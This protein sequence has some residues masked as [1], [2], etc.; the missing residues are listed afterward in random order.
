M[1]L[2]ALCIETWRS[3]VAWSMGVILLRLFGFA[4]VMGVALRTM[5]RESIGLWYGMLS[6]TALAASVELGFSGTI[7]RM[8]S[9]YYAGATSVPSLGLTGIQGP[10]ARPNAG[11]LDGVIA[12]ARRV[13]RVLAVL[14]LALSA[15]AAVGWVWL[16]PSSQRL[17]T[18]ALAALALLV[19]GGT[20]NLSALFWPS[21][22]QGIHEV[23]ACNIYVALGFLA[24][25]ATALAGLGLGAGLVALAAGQ[26]VQSLA[27]RWLARRHVLRW[28]ES[29]E[30]TPSVRTRWQT[31]WPMTWRTGLAQ[32][33]AQLMLPATP[34]LLTTFS[35]AEAGS[36]GVSL[37]AA[38]LLHTLTASWIAVK[39]PV[40]SSLRASRQLAIVR[41]MA[42]Q[43]LALT[44][45]SFVACALVVPLLA[46]TVLSHIGSRTPFVTTEI[47]AMLA[48]ATGI[49]LFIGAHAALIQT[50]N[51]VSYLPAFVITGLVNLCA[52]AFLARSYGTTGVL[53]SA[54]VSPLL[55]NAWWLPR[56]AWRQL[57]MREH[58][59][60]PRFDRVRTGLGYGFPRFGPLAFKWFFKRAP[61]QCRV[62]LFP[63]IFI[64][65]DFSDRTFQSTY[66]QGRRF[67][68]PSCQML[69]AWFN[70]PR[71]TRFMDIGANYGFFSY[72][73]LTHHPTIEVYAFDPHP[74]NS[75]FQ[76]TVKEEN[77]L[78][79]FHPHAIGLSDAEGRLS[80]TLGNEDRGHSCF[81]NH[82]GLADQPTV[83]VFVRAFDDWA[84]EEFRVADE[85]PGSWI[86]KIDVEGFELN[87]LRGMRRM[88]TKKM[89][90]GLMVE[91]NPFT[92]GLMGIR[93][94]EIVDWLADI[95]YVVSYRDPRCP[96]V[97]F[98]PSADW[99]A[100]TRVDVVEA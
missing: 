4:A 11:A 32:A 88:L 82:P 75:P 6:L 80:L 94:Q 69:A 99:A 78:D 63:D 17:S 15:S 41:R 96:N 19:A 49:D 5:P 60:V 62:Q 10:M 27:T 23:R 54:I 14:Y 64:D 13:Y 45:L 16:L 84:A 57:A 42:A 79:R 51:R 97:F 76:R 40:F 50:G 36:Y 29:Q 71:V 8:A 74:F 92:L 30:P 25:Y 56:D 61:A 43:R 52:G 55:I 86:A 81:T 65:A 26:I 87:V 33:A 18:Q 47:W 38:L 9:Y 22:L 91:I 7:A 35:L 28:L 34:L 46:P 72:F 3:S 98:V 89:F 95:G 77:R 70:D 90:A 37:Q 93:S 12:E 100:R 44:M 20:L 67:E 21:V 73:A 2:R 66:W 24:G 48:I 31:F 85:V 68:R 58:H 53:T 59:T 39:W 83:D 1:T